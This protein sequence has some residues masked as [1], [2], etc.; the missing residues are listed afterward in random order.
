MPHDSLRRTF[1]LAALA[2]ISI[3]F[4]FQPP[5]G[6]F[7]MRYYDGSQWTEHVSNGGAQQVDAPSGFS[8]VPTVNR[9]LEKIQ[10]DVAKPAQM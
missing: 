2:F 9:P 7:E 6:R 3:D 10:G 4:Y 8:V 5:Y 1:T